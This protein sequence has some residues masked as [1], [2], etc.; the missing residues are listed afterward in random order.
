MD[1]LIKRF[2]Q[3][4]VRYLLVGGQAMRLKG[5]PRFSMDRDFFI[6]P[7]KTKGWNTDLKCRR[8]EAG[9]R[10]TEAR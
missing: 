5:M 9:S 2:N 1:E 8:P 7:G 10:R 3:A 4:Q 6:P